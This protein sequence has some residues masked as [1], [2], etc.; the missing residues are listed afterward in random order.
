MTSY[1]SVAFGVALYLYGKLRWKTKIVKPEEM[2]IFGD[3][4]LM[5]DREDDCIWKP[6]ME[7]RRAKK[8]G[9]VGD[10]VDKWL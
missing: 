9:S 4:K 6:L 5:F 3:E 2:E 8:T 10:W 7:R 1:F